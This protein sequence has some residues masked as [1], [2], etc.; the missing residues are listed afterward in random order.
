MKV[1]FK[2][3]LLSLVLVQMSLLS[4]CDEPKRKHLTARQMKAY[5]EPLRKVNRYLVK[6]DEEEIRSYCQ[7]RGWKMQMSKTGLWYACLKETQGQQVQQGDWVEIK[8]S[9]SL[10]NGKTIYDSDSLGT[11]QFE[12]GHGGVESGLEEGILMMR[13]HEKYRFIMQPYQ[14]HGLLGD[15]NKIPARSIIIYNVEL[16]RLEK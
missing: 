14:A 9:V 10:L 3:F 5:E 6:K 1:V 16:L 13:E 11:K 4:S 15:L 8:F 2:I 7:R 12:V